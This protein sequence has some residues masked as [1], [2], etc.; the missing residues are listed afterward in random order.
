MVVDIETEEGIL[1]LLNSIES[2]TEASV[3]CRFILDNVKI[4]QLNVLDLNKIDVP[5]VRTILQS[6]IEGENI[7]EAIKF[8]I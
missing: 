6:S 8:L 7:R 3:F 2:T 5:Y 4:D 1:E